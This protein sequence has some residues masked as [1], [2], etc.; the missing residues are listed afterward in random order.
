MPPPEVYHAYYKY[1]FFVRPE[2]LREGWDRD[3]IIEA[4]MAEGIPCFSGICPEVYLEKA[5]EGSLRPAE[6]LP[7]AKEL[8]ETSL[9]VMVHPTLTVED[10]ADTGRALAKV[11]EAATR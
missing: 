1:Y 9:M 4:V 2:A 11:L 10:V 6:R 3:R 5:F 8:G 7:V